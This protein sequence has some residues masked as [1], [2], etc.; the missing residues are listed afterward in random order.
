[1]KKEIVAVLLGILTVVFVMTISYLTSPD[2]QRL[3]DFLDEL[4]RED[5]EKNKMD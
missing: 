2:E 1:M 5:D 3:E 4:D